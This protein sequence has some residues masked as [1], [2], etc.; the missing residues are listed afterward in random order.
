MKQGTFIAIIFWAGVC[1]LAFAQG[2]AETPGEI[3]VAP[4]RIPACSLTPPYEQKG[5]F[6]QGSRLEVVG[7]GA[8]NMIHVRLRT[9]D[10]RSIEALCQREALASSARPKEAV[11]AGNPVWFEDSAGHQQAVELQ[12]KSDEPLLIFFHADWN[13]ECQF[14]WKELLDNQ[15][16]KNGAK[17]IVKL[18][19]NPEHGQDEGQL[20]RRYKLRKYPTTLV[21]DKPNAKPRHIELFYW[22]F[23]R[24]KTPPIEYALGSVLGTETNRKPWAAKADEP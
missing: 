2:M 16:F 24:M 4:H 6:S 20:A 13:D 19:I 23:G 10:G 15:D 8:N 17:N 3:I 1:G 11:A 21:V 9:P 5:F 18:K 12:S 22:S 7:K 14:L